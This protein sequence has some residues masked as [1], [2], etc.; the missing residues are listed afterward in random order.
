MSKKNTAAQAAPEAKALSIPERAVQAIGYN[1]ETV[2]ALTI[3]AETNKH[4]VAITNDD[5]REQANRARLDLRA[6]RLEISRRGKL[7]RE[8]ATAYSKA[9]IAEEARLVALVEP[10]EDRLAR[11]VDAFDAEIEAEKQRKAQA[12]LDRVTALQARVEAIRRMIDLPVNPEPQYVLDTITEVEAVTID[13]SFEEYEQQAIE[14]KR[15]TLYY[16]NEQHEAAVAR[17]AREE[18]ARKDAEELAK[19]RAEKAERDRAER[20]RLQRE[21]D[22]R[23]LRIEADERA[24]RERQA[25]ERGR[26][27]AASAA[28]RQQD[29]ARQPIIATPGINDDDAAGARAEYLNNLSGGFAARADEQLASLQQKADV[30]HVIECAGTVESVSGAGLVTYTGDERPSF[31]EIVRAVAWHFETDEATARTWIADPLTFIGWLSGDIP[32]LHR[33]EVPR[34]A[35]SWARFNG[36]AV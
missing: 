35:D 10:E 21:T 27:M 1:V 12:E 13:A 22:E 2:Q 25:E 19:L 26:A 9:V 20:E 34:L 31:D 14:A 5:G 24:E 28:T 11:L 36:R 16:L 17:I 29:A 33:V 4:I 23:R 7:A 8:D 15:A 3:L 30:T 18:Q 32:E 6:A